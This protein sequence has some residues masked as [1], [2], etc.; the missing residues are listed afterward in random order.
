[1]E[2]TL[3]RLRADLDEIDG[4]IAALFARRMKTVKEIGA[5]KAEHGAPILDAARQAQVLKRVCAQVDPEIE[6]ETTTLFET[7]M[8]LSRAYQQK[9]NA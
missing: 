4:Q 2:E 7:I 6:T 3:V 8:S 9:H 1:M 5:W